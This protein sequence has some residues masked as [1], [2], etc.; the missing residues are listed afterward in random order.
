MPGPQRAPW[1][2]LEQDTP[3]RVGGEQ[4]SSGELQ[5]TEVAPDTLFGK[6]VGQPQVRGKSYHHQS[7]NV[8]GAKLKVVATHPDGTIEAI[9][10]TDRPW[11]VAVQWHPERTPEDEATQRLF[12]AFVDAARS[13]RASRRQA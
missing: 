13:Y 7:V 5:E 1:R 8:P 11:L 9:E 6:I 4:D 12:A 3:D 10:A 2:N